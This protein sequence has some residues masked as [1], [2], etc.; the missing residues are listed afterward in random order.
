M[1]SRPLQTRAALARGDRHPDS[2]H[3]DSRGHEQLTDGG[4][5]RTHGPKR[6]RL[7]D[8]ESTSKLIVRAPP[9]YVYHIAPF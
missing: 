5:E 9:C 7:A 2:Q 8:A 3:E 1:P 6:P 4:A